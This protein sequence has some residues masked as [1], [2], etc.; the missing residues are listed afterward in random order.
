MKLRKEELIECLTTL[1]EQ[2]R[3]FGD[4][5]TFMVDIKIDS[6]N[7]VIDTTIKELEQ[8]QKTGYWIVMCEGFSPLECSQCASVQFKKSNYC[9][10]CGARMSE[11]EDV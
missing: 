9:P 8:E 11:S 2:A 4:N 6:L 7:Y 1:K 10:S 5:N 3:E